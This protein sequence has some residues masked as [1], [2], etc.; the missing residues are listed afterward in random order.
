MHT[1]VS[2]VDTA[3]RFCI[4]MQIFSIRFSLIPFCVPIINEIDVICTI[5]DI[6]LDSASHIDMKSVMSP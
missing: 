1:Y 5:L 3:H 2:Q 4:K 6:L